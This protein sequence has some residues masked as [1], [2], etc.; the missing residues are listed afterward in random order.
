MSISFELQ[1]QQAVE[2]PELFRPAVK[3]GLDIVWFDRLA[4]LFGAAAGEF[5]EVVGIDPRTLTRRRNEGKLTT[6]ESSSLYH[7]LVLYVH[8]LDVLGGP[9]AVRNWLHA[10]EADFADM[11]PFEL[12]DTAP[13]IQEVDQLLGR[14]EHGVF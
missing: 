2:N 4:E 5:A 9:E 10:P 13:G 1:V 8:A 7:L 3:E 14:I 6:R 11:K 12:L